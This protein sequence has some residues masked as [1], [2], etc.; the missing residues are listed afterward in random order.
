[1]QACRPA[2]EIEWLRNELPHALATA[3]SMTTLEVHSPVRQILYRDFCEA[4]V[5]IAHLRHRHQPTLQQRLQSLLQHHILP[6]AQV[7]C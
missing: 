1:M 5:R 7:T 6:H 4:L 2:A 3:V